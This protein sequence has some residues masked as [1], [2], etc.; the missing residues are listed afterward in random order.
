MIDFL[1]TKDKSNQGMEAR[2]VANEEVKD[3]K[4]GIKI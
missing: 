2:N 1:R 3:A 4:R